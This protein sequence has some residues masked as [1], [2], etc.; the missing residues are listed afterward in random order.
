MLMKLSKKLIRRYQKWQGAGFVV[1]FGGLIALIGSLD[2]SDHT[3]QDSLVFGVSIALTIIGAA[4]VTYFG[5]RI[6]D[7]KEMLELKRAR[8]EKCARELALPKGA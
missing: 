4:M 6:D 5:K 3:G 8:N 2:F 7:E 1:E